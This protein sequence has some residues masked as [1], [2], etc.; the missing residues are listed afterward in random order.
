MRKGVK[1]LLVAACL[2]A[3]VPPHARAQSCVG[4]PPGDVTVTAAFE[5]TDAHVGKGLDAAVGFVDGG[6]F[7][8]AYRAMENGLD[9]VRAE[10]AVETGSLP[11]PFC[12]TAG[13]WWLRRD[14]QATVWEGS[15]FE[16][17][18]FPVGVA[19]GHRFES[20]GAHALDVFLNPA[21]V[22]ARSVYEVAGSAP[23]EP[24]YHVVPG[25]SFGLALS[26]GPVM[27]RGVVRHAFVPPPAWP[28]EDDFPYLSLQLGWAF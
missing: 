9:V 6:A 28:R 4:I 2:P 12:M 7:A 20:G 21:M 24:V 8:V 5:G 14:V 19:I 18:R 11:V 17:W 3:V 13:A 25:G 23:E 15:G 27:L 1:H 26:V 22:L 10:L 16:N